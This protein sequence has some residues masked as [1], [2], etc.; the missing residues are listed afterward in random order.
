MK[1]VHYVKI[2][3]LHLVLQLVLLLYS[4]PS[5]SFEAYSEAWLE[6]VKSVF[7]SVNKTLQSAAD[8]ELNTDRLEEIKKKLLPIRE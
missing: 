3:P 1:A 4:S 7:E 8:Q 5:W 6:S 2:S